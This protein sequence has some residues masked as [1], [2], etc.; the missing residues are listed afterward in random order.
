MKYRGF[1]SLSY[2]SIFALSLLALS[3]TTP[4]HAQAVYGTLIGTVTDATGASVS[5]A[6]VTRRNIINHHQ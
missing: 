5:G 6:K 1:E 2:L 4:L 3:A